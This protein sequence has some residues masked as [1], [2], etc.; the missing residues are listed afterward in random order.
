M[1]AGKSEAEY[2]KDRTED[3][4]NK[5]KAKIKEMVE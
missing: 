1:D 2:L 3:G 4:L 5:G